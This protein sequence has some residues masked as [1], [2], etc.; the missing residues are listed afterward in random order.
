MIEN[1]YWK[2]SYIFYTI[3]YHQCKILFVWLLQNSYKIKFQKKLINFLK[4]CEYL[5]TREIVNLTC[6]YLHKYEMLAQLGTWTLS[7]QWLPRVM[8]LLFRVIIC[9]YGS[10]LNL[11]QTHFNPFEGRICPVTSLRTLRS[12]QKF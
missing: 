7:N 9:G 2:D 3:Q 10:V 12:S 5:S 1:K 6:L 4:I 8:G 11:M